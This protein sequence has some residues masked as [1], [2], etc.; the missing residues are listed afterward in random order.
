MR[1]TKETSVTES[2]SKAKVE[3]T[4]GVCVKNSEKTIGR[5]IQSV[6][7]QDY[8][9]ELMEVVVVDGDS[10]D[11]TL[12]IV[13]KTLSKGGRNVRIYSDRGGGLGKA[14]QIVVENA[15]GSYI[16]WVDGDV[17]LLKDLVKRHVEFLRKN[18]RVGVAVGEYV[19]LGGTLVASLQS[20]RKH[21]VYS[22]HTPKRGVPPP[23]ANGAIYL[24]QA[25][26]D[27]GGFDQNIKGAGE[28]LD[29]IMRIVRNGWLFCLNRR[30]KFR[31]AFKDTWRDL[32]AE[33]FW[34][35]YGH[36]YLKHKHKDLISLWRS[37]P[38][39]SFPFGLKRAS[40]A[41]RLTSKK[42]SF[43]LPLLFLFE[44]VGM[45][46]GFMRGHLNHYVPRESDNEA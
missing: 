27:V 33:Q 24:V 34:F 46:C 31:H 36:H 11:R 7:D 17:V 16:I 21:A 2:S 29:L 40:D 32:W 41:Y 39:L 26:R 19:N 45:W 25:V 42:K 20:L 22:G 30:A 23:D 38:P 15:H 37:A 13:T 28:D 14:R 12:S 9:S 8:P 3:V 4:I 44:N 6:V 5:A 35:G 10:K 18:P 1:R 43:L